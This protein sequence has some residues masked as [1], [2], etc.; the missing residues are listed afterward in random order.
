M[1]GVAEHRFL[2]YPDSGCAAL[3]D[4]EPVARVRVLVEEVRPDTVLTF[5]P[6]WGT[7]H[8]DHISVG[9]WTTFACRSAAVTPRLLYAANTPEWIARFN[10][11]LNLDTVMMAEGIDQPTTPMHELSPHRV[12]DDT[13]ADRKVRALRCQASR[14]EPL[15]AQTGVEALCDLVR[16]ESFRDPTPHGWP[17]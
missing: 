2:D 10:V 9:R 6:D 5:G 15:I 17:A 8:Q 4:E 16:E 11:A 3:P 1:L 14:V 13:L 12:A 7:Y